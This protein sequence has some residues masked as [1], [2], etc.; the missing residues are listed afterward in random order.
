M[1]PHHPVRGAAREIPSRRDAESR[2][3]LSASPRPCVNAI[4]G[5]SGRHHTVFADQSCIPT[6]GKCL[7]QRTGEPEDCACFLW[8]SGSLG[9]T[10]LP[11]CTIK[12][13]KWYQGA[14]DCQASGSRRQCIT[15]ITR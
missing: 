8:S 13:Q 2:C 6:G 15:A 3:E 7:T 10:N 11:E 14:R 5:T 4:C 12:N 1:L 9:E